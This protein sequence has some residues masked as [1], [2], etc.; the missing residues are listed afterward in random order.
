MIFIDFKHDTNAPSK[1]SLAWVDL[2]QANSIISAK[3]LDLRTTS[4]RPCN[5]RSGYATYRS[6]FDGKFRAQ[7]LYRIVRVESSDKEALLELMQVLSAI[8]HRSIDTQV[9][10]R[11]K[12]Q[13]R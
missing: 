6:A 13:K 4:S 8:M 12:S 7:L 10:H 1:A 2:R 5:G 3:Y 11:S 9:G